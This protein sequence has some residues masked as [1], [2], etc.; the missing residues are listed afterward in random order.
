MD[1]SDTNMG[2]TDMSD[3]DTNLND[4]DTASTVSTQGH[5]SP[6]NASGPISVLASRISSR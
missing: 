1:I 4:T 5:L 2:D 6:V 3:T